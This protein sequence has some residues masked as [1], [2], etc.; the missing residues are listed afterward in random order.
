MRHDASFHTVL[1][2]INESSPGGIIL[3]FKEKYTH[4][5][6]KTEGKRKEGDL[7]LLEGVREGNCISK[8]E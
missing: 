8:Y 1:A 3:C 5:K 2:Y 6:K 7:H 4:R